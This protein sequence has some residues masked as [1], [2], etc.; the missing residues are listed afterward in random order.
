[1]LSWKNEKAG[2]W[3]TRHPS[4]KEVAAYIGQSF[5]VPEIAII[6]PKLVFLM[7]DESRVH[8]IGT[9]QTCPVKTHSRCI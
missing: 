1:M 5:I 9:S 4:S 3:E 8:S 2:K 6:K 7:V